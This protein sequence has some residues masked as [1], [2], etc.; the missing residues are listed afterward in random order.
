[1]SATS[2]TISYSIFCGNGTI[3]IIAAANSGFCYNNDLFSKYNFLENTNI[4]G[5]TIINNIFKPINTGGYFIKITTPS[6]II[7]SN[8][9]YFASNYSNK[10]TR[11]TT[12]FS[13]LS[14]WADSIGQEANSILSD[15]LFVNATI[16]NYILM[17]NSPAI[18]AGLNIGYTTIGLPDIGAIET[19]ATETGKLYVNSIAGS[20]TSNG[21]LSFPLKTNVGSINSITLLA[22]NT[23][24]YERGKKFDFLTHLS[25]SRH[26][27]SN[28][29]ILVLLSKE[30]KHHSRPLLA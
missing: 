5:W 22:G 10:W 19:T 17:G 13:T 8:N 12:N 9:D 7:A 4:N 18:N 26:G 14:S 1:M 16:G 24:Y 11:G 2:T 23:I 25:Q 6:A 20:D 28:S 15:P 29:S 30:L 3:D 27:I 21:T